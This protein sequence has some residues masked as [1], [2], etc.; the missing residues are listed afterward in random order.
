MYSIF[1]AYDLPIY[2]LLAAQVARPSELPRDDKYR[3]ISY[4][5]SPCGM[6]LVYSQRQPLGVS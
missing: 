6:G 2:V 3:N 1:I 4:S 5:V